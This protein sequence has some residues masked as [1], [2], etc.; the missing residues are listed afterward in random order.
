MPEEFSVVSAC[1]GR[2]PVRRPWPP[3]VATLLALG[4]LSAPHPSPAQETTETDVQGWIQY[5]YQHR[6]SDKWRGSW[7]LGYRE[8]LSTEDVLG[9]WS[10]LHTRGIFSYVHRNWV[11]FD[12]GIAAYY[13]FSEN[14][15]DLF[16][17]RSWQSAVLFWPTAKLWGKNF[18]LRHRFRLEQRWIRQQDTVDKDFGLRFRYRVHPTP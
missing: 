2:L 5:E 18:D 6:I 8:L 4:F 3:I 9:Q 15:T 14:L 1:D 17:L 12:G 7:D 10:R 13:T 16:E 11:T